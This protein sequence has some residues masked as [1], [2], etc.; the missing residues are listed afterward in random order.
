M[1]NRNPPE[2]RGKFTHSAVESMSTISGLLE[3]GSFDFSWAPYATIKRNIGVR[4]NFNAKYAS[5]WNNGY[6]IYFRSEVV[7]PWGKIERMDYTPVV[8]TSS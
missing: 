8:R 5:I 6:K 3:R 2:L 4:F 7:V 1:N